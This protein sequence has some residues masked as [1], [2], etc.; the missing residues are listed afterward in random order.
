MRVR[1]VTAFVLATIAALS[2]TVRAQ[3]PAPQTLADCL[4]AVRDYVATTYKAE[5]SAGR[6]PDLAAI[7]RKKVELAK[8]YAARFPVESVSGADLLTLARLASEAGDAV[9]AGEALAKR[10]A[11]PDLSDADRAT[12][13]ATGVEVSMASP[14]TEAGLQ[15]AE[16]FAAALDKIPSATM[17][18]LEAHNRL[19]GYFRAVDVDQKILDHMEKVRWTRRGSSAASSSAGTPPRRQ[20]S[21]SWWRNCSASSRGRVRAKEK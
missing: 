13:L 12:A 18:R 16:E 11:V 6:V 5:R 14:I 3:A 15:R 9:L 20:A 8:E 2:L 4:K 19:G 21:G 1:F 17:P 7:N 10:L